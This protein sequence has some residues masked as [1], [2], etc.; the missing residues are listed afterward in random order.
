MKASVIDTISACS[1]LS[2]E[3]L[4]VY[5]IMAKGPAAEY[6]SECIRMSACIRISVSGCRVARVKKPAAA[7]EN[8]SEL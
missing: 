4:T 3:Y 6:N 2:I 1:L 5:S 8:Y 7:L